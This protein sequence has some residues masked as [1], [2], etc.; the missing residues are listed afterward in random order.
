MDAF[1]LRKPHPPK[2]VSM[3]ANNTAFIN[4]HIS[5]WGEQVTRR[6]DNS[7]ESNDT[8]EVAPILNALWCLKCK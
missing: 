8:K 4:K 1:H 6:D 2:Y 3:T 7:T 5:Q